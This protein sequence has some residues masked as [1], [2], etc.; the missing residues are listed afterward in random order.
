MPS[1]TDKDERLYEHI[2]DSQ[3]DRGESEADAKVVAAR[4][5]NKQRREEGRTPNNSTQGTGNPNL[6]LDEL[7]VQELRNRA[8]ELKIE[9]RSKMKKTALIEAIRNG[10]T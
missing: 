10:R 2:K 4:T 9:G 7:T 6:P 3:L 5:V 1:W 8:S